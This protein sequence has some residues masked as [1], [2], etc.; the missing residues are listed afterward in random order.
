MQSISRSAGM[1][2]KYQ[3]RKISTEPKYSVKRDLSIFVPLFPL[4]TT[5]GR[6]WGA[7]WL[8]INLWMIVYLA[9]PSGL[10]SAGVE[11]VSRNPTFQLLTLR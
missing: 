11:E 2:K 3:K 10:T 9:H 5:F 4:P 7:Y 1:T 8:S 6:R